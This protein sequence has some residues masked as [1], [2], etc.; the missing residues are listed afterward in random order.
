MRDPGAGVW[1]PRFA[2]D[3][4]RLDQRS[5][6]DELPALGAREGPGFGTIITWSDNP[7]WRRAGMG[8]P[9]KVIGEG[10]KPKKPRKEDNES[11]YVGV[12]QQLLVGEDRQVVEI[13]AGRNFHTV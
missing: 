3:G 1:Q 5:W 6:M 13:A 10:T 11:V 12:K 8:S 9:G 4:L 2:A 7:T